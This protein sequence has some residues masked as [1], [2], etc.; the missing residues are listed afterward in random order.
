[1]IPEG[2]FFPAIDQLFQAKKT[3]VSS[4]QLAGQKTTRARNRS[5]LVHAE[6]HHDLQQ[7]FVLN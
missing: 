7:N 2:I 1:M 6:V 4:K 5:T 3:C